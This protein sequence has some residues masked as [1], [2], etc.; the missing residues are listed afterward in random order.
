MDFVLIE[1]AKK[2]TAG[3]SVNLKVVLSKKEVSLKQ[4][5]EEYLSV[6]VFD[7]SD[8]FTFPIWNNVD[9]HKVNLNEGTVYHLSGGISFYQNNF[10]IKDPVLN[11]TDDS[12]QDFLPVYEIPQSL[13]DYFNKT[14]DNLESPWKEFVTACIKKVDVKSMLQAP[15]ATSHHHARIGGLF[16]HTCGLLKNVDNII[17]LYCDNPFWDFKSNI[18]PS[19]LRAK[20]IL[21]DIMKTKEYAYTTTIGR[22]KFIADHRFMANG[23]FAVVN[24]QTKLLTEEQ[25]D[26]LSYSVMSHHGKYGKEVVP[27]QSLEDVLLHAVDMIDSQTIKCAET[28]ETKIP[29][30]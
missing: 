6:T 29:G 9:H 8:S 2:M 19:R 18:N 24:E 5:K 11:K 30:I 27:P 25:L 21:H 17:N 22:N 26:D 12:P 4:N 7:Q 1:N 14:I 15:A 3:D 10:Q 28:G 16:L 13:K 23:L 20:A